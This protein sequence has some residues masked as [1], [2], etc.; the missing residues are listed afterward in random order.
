MERLVE[1]RLGPSGRLDQAF[2]LF[3]FAWH[4]LWGIIR[5]QHPD[6]TEQK[7]RA[8]VCRRVQDIQ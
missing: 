4:H 2:A 8:E 3:E 7:V 6:W 5:D 1:D